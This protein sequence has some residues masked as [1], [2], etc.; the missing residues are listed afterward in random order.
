MTPCAYWESLQFYRS[1]EHSQTYLSVFSVVTLLWLKWW[2]EAVD[3]SGEKITSH[4][5]SVVFDCCWLVLRFCCCCGCCWVLTLLSIVR[6]LLYIEIFSNVVLTVSLLLDGVAAQDMLVS[7]DMRPSP[8]SAKPSTAMNSW[9][10]SRKSRPVSWSLTGTVI[11][12]TLILLPQPSVNKK[13]SRGFI[14]KSK[15]KAQI[16]NH[17]STRK[18][19]WWNWKSVIWNALVT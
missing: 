16:H 13:G 9:K 2:C 11:R 17:P 4:S 18:T 19:G 8:L 3:F 15:A 10:Q 6:V 7:C 14:R 1:G 12:T 5:E